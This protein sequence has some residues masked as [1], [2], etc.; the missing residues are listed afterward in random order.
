MKHTF[1]LIGIDHVQFEPLFALTDEQLRSHHAVRCYT[2]ASPGYPCRISLEDAR[3]G[4]ELLLLPYVHQPAPSPYR[5]SGPIYVR[6]GANQRK[7]PAGVVPSYVTSRLISLRAYDSEH[8]IVSAT[9]CEGHIAAQEIE[10]HFGNESVA[11]IHLHNAKRGCFSCNVI[12][13]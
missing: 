1:Q 8:M 13:A 7:L 12:R 4:D 6:R 9:V 5:A 11:Y 3:V 10:Q 2:T